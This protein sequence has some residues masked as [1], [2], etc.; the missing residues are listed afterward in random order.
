MNHDPKVGSWGG[1]ATKVRWFSSPAL[2]HARRLTE[3]PAD[4]VVTNFAVCD[5]RDMEDDQR[6]IDGILRM[7]I[8]RRLLLRAAAVPALAGSLRLGSARTMA[9]APATPDA[10]PGSSADTAYTPGQ[11]VLAIRTIGASRDAERASISYFLNVSLFD[12]SEHAEAAYRQ[13]VTAAVPELPPGNENALQEG[14]DAPDVG[15]ERR[16]TR[17]DMSIKGAMTT[18]VSLTAWNDKTL[19]EWI[20]FSIYPPTTAS[21]VTGAANVPAWAEEMFIVAEKAMHFID[22][23][24]STDTEVFA[25]LPAESD[26]PFAVGAEDQIFWADPRPFAF[27][28]S[29]PSR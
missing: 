19:H 17:L 12:S 24:L 23:D 21:D 28:S 3:A 11:R 10:T 7:R 20:L 4:A 14:L 29:S 6:P 2:C 22:D 5:S 16:A 18:R 15:N 13:H 8:S 27:P 9:V 26:I 25:L 1:A